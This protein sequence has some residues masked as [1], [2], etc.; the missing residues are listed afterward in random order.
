M[1]NTFH[2]KLNSVKRQTDVDIYSGP[3]NK[4]RYKITHMQALPFQVHVRTSH[5]QG[6]GE[7]SVLPVL[8]RRITLTGSGKLP[9][10]AKKGPNK[11]QT[12]YLPLGKG[13]GS[14]LLVF[15]IVDW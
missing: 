8:Q 3:T 5:I 1:E 2:R 4:R 6:F 11:G 14:W 10:V 9:I 12:P 13:E 7:L 15:I